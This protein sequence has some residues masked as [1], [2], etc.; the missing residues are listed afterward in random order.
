VQD[1]L[2]RAVAIH[3]AGGLTIAQVAARCGIGRTSLTDALVARRAR[4]AEQT[5]HDVAAAV[6][7]HAKLPPPLARR[8]DLLPQQ[9][10]KRSH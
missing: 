4:I 6:A 8:P 3:D 5:R 7:R 2:L 1:R 9:N 10:T